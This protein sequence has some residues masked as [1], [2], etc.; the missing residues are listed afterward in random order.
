MS[1]IQELYTKAKSL[2]KNHPNAAVESK[3]LVLK[4]LDISE[5]EFYSHPGQR[6]SKSKVHQFYRLVLKRQQGIPLAY[7]V[8]EKEFW[9]LL[10]KVTHGVLIPRPETELLVEKVI[11]LSSRGKELIVDIGTG[12]GNIAVSIAKELTQARIVATDVSQQAL[13]QA[14]INADLQKV[15]RIEFVRGSFFGPLQK[16]MLQGKSDFI[17]SNPPYV[18]E[19]EWERLSEEIRNHEPKR[20]LVPGKTGLEFIKKLIQQ[21]PAFL[22]PRGYLCLEMG[23]DQKER[24]LPF[25]GGAWQDPQCFS[26]ING[27]PRVVVAQPL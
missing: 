18:S 5:E 7:V 6:I 12:A 1:T 26:D 4:S 22:R 2:L 25:F 14:K 15:P 23:C 10:F 27:I 24:V 17:V 16:L 8:G 20:A 21:A 19:K 3:V 11:E 9:S 13:E